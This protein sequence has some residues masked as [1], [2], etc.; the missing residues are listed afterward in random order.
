MANQ[1]YKS[2]EELPVMLTDPAGGKRTQHI[3]GR[4]LR[5]GP[6]QKLSVHADWQQDRCSQG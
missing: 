5:A 6:Q 3:Q 1:Y 4:R 2:F